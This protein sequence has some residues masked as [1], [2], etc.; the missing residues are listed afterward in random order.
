[1]NKLCERFEILLSTW[2][3]GELDDRQEGRD[4]LD[5]LVRCRD[6][7][8]FYREAR[9]LEGVIVAV[10]SAS[11]EPAPEAVWR[12]IEGEARA[13]ERKKVRGWMLKAA[14][15]AI[16]AVGLGFLVVPR[17]A[18]RGFLRTETSGIRDI[19]VDV[20]SRAG[21]MT[22]TR[23]LEITTE[24]LEA[25]ARYR[26]AMLEVMAVVNE[27][28]ETTEGGGDFASEAGERERTSEGGGRA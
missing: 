28:S 7:R 23:F 8:G 10:D 11:A 12:R 2:L 14:V 16:V 15:L 9:T 17:M 26:R 27:G 3:D 21:R 1:M 19:E 20:G 4:M 24:I 22:E 25:D 5:H 18:S 13:P 6:C